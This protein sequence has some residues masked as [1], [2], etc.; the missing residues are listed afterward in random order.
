MN[1]DVD[2][3]VLLLGVEDVAASK[4]FYVERGLAVGKS[5]GSYVRLADAVEPGRPRLLQSAMTL[6]GRRRRSRGQWVAPAAHHQRRERSPTPPG[7]R[8]S[9]HR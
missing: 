1:R 3:I 5:F 9:P 4:R 7:S 8:A 6:A 2:K